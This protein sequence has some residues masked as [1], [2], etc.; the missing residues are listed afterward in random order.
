MC[1]P[2]LTTQRER[3]RERE[4]SIPTDTLDAGIQ[5]QLAWLSSNLEL[6]MTLYKGGGTALDT[7]FLHQ[8][9]DPVVGPLRILIRITLPQL[10]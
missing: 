1:V 10:I 5:G 6:K 9:L 8:K 4:R 2:H 3:E 7:G